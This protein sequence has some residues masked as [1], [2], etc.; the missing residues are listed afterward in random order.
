MREW[1]AKNY[2]WVFSGSGVTAITATFAGLAAIIGYF[3]KR[4][5]APAAANPAGRVT[6]TVL[7]ASTAS[8]IAGRDVHQTIN[9][10]TTRTQDSEEDAQEFSR[11]PTA[12][13]I[14]MHI[15]R[16]PIMQRD[17]FGRET[18]GG[19]KV[20]WQLTIKFIGRTDIPGVVE[21]SMFTR[22]GLGP[23]VQGVVILEKYQR[24]KSIHGDELV[25][26]WGTIKHASDS[27]IDLDIGRLT[28]DS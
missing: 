18:Y 17:K 10:T 23:L 16:L 13:E 27:G 7:G 1:L 11:H 2:T 5:R 22:K 14:A 9:I 26:I 28:F 20:K 6:S 8:P 3:L 21:L 4:R 15:E 25:T 19:L 12:D 24:L